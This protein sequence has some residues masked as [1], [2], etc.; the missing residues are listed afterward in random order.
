MIKKK[1]PTWT[2]ICFLS[3]RGSLSRRN[4]KH[5]EDG[6]LC[7][8]G[9]QLHVSLGGQTRI[10]PH[11]WRCQ[12]SDLGLPLSL[13][14]TQGYRLRACWGSAHLQKRQE[15]CDLFVLH[16]LSYLNVFTWESSDLAATHSM[17]YAVYSIIW[18][19]G[20]KRTCE[21]CPFSFNHVPSSNMETV[22]FVTHNQWLFQVLT[23]DK[24]LCSLF[25]LSSLLSSADHS[26]SHLLLLCSHVINVNYTSQTCA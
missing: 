14:C 26:H 5:V 16:F 17:S 18:L 12:L 3:S 20:K 1:D 9:R 23:C 2:N 11:G 8:S 19:G 21:L 7:S 10:C 24:L 13:G 4:V 15:K 25:L 6:R 22:G